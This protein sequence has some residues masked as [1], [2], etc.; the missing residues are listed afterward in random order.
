MIIGYAR[1]STQDQTPE[2]QVDALEKAGCEQIFQEKF[3]G[4]FRERPELSQCLR[5]LRMG[6]VLIVWKLDRLARSLKDL[7]EIVQDLNDRDI[8]FKSLTES[9]DTTNSGGR[10]IFHIFGA[11]AEFEHDLIRERTKAGLQAA[12]A[13]GRKGGRKPAMSDS[14]IRKAAAMLSDSQI[15]KT[16]VAAHFGVTRT[17][18]NASLK[19]MKLAA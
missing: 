19:R 13:R 6:D 16:E 5:T 8:G 4:K 3:T 9:I 15:T 1:V 12:R 14:D 2:F 7:V 18:L 11:L 10:L 17:T